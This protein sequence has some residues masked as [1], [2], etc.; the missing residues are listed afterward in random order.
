MQLVCP[1]CAGH[2][3]MKIAHVAAVTAFVRVSQCT[4][5]VP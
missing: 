2:R 1:S 5:T 4:E 3:R